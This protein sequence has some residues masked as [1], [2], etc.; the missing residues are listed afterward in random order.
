RSMRCEEKR[1]YIASPKLHV[2]IA[3]GARFIH[4]LK[5]CRERGGQVVV[6]N[7][8]REPGLVR[9]AVPR[10]ATSMLSGGSEIASMFLQPNIGEDIALFK[11]LAKAIL[12]SQAEDE[13]FIA[14]Y[15]EGFDAFAAD[16]RATPWRRIETRTGIARTRI[17]RVAGLYARARSVVFAWGMGMTH[18][19]HGVE[20]IEYISN[21]ALLRGM[22]GRPGAGLLPLRGHSNVQG[23]G[24]I[25]VKPVLPADVFDQ[26]EREFGIELSRTPGWDTMAA[27]QA[28]ERGDVDAAV[29]MGG[30]LF[31]SNPNSAWAE[32]ALNR[33]GFR[34]CLTTTL[35]LSHVRGV[36]A[37]EVLILP[38]AARD[39][40]WQP[41]TQ[42]SMFNYVRLSDGQ[43]MRHA[44]VRPEVT[45]L[46]DLATRLLPDTPIDFQAFKQHRHVREVIAATVPG[47]AE[48]ADI[49]V[50]RREFHVAHRLLHESEFRTPSRKVAFQTR[51][52][53]EH[54]HNPAN[55]FRLTTVRSEGQFNSIIYEEKDSYRK[56]ETRW[57]VL[58]NEDDMQALQLSV[59]AKVN[60]TSEHGHMHG[61][62]V[63]AH[64][65]PRGNAMAYFPEANCLTGTSVDPRSMT[66][67]FKHTTVRVTPA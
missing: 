6:I 23:I 64:A 9:F 57:C 43:I 28:S 3:K 18:H 46:A 41:T 30:N 31:A 22:V 10:S 15:A 32:R 39:E 53:P 24:T 19:Q 58:L 44:N 45:I 33:I 26:L 36:D 51:Q 54:G 38:V 20:N 7:P 61:V 35:N 25:G 56:T 42:E 55:A 2:A 27:M 17:E 29:L 60:L 16:V 67:A 49:D 40:E 59:G 8:A 66:P 50:A 12:E 4:K 21:L 1:S 63:Y 62:T 48:L 52:M 34:L 11:G 14:S 5:A 65:L 13:A 47:M 37:G